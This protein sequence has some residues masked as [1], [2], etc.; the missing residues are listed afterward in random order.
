MPLPLR[1][2]RCPEPCLNRGSSICH[3]AHKCNCYRE[4][5]EW[6]D[7]KLEYHLKK[8][9]QNKRNKT[10]SYNHGKMMRD[11]MTVSAR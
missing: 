5:R 2:P 9:E 8:C 11:T 7:A 3:N 1:P 4:Q 6:Y 10:G